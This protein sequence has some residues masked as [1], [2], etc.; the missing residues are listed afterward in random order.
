MES[1]V[2]DEVHQLGL[3]VL[4]WSDDPR[5]WSAPR[6]AA[7]AKR[8]LLQL[9]S[10]AVV[11]LHDRGGY[12]TQTVAALACLLAQL[13]QGGCHLSLPTPTQ[14]SPAAAAPDDQAVR[15]VSA[16]DRT[17]RCACDLTYSRPFGESLLSSP[18]ARSS[19]GSSTA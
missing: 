2:V 9:R 14:I 15:D 3:S 1:A 10:G 7:I 6:V 4:R 19:F 8:V 11:L 13:P 5:D 18:C 16:Y 12:R 17:C